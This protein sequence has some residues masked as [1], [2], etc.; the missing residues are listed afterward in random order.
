MQELHEAGFI[1]TLD[2]LEADLFTQ[3]K[4]CVIQ[5]DTETRLEA[6]AQLLD[7]LTV[8]NLNEVS[9]LTSKNIRKVN[10]D[11]NLDHIHEIAHYNPL[12]RFWQYLQSVDTSGSAVLTKLENKA[13]K[14]SLL[15]SGLIIEHMGQNDRK[16]KKELSRRKAVH[17]VLRRINGLL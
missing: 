13:E 11:S 17:K 2:N 3:A 7:S 4:K 9:K 10:I 16:Y 12:Y 8:A 6:L 1:V 15:Y 5:P 14:L